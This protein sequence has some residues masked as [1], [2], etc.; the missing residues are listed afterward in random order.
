MWNYL[1][2]ISLIKD[3]PKCELNG[4]ELEIYSQI[5]TKSINWIPVG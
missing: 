3:K 2:L 4:I 5:E 1:F